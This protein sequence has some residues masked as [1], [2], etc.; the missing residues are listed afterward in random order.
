MSLESL[1]NYKH[2]YS[3]YCRLQPISLVSSFGV[4]MLPQT[5][6]DWDGG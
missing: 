3:I 5:H 6:G 1:M 4:K 2:H